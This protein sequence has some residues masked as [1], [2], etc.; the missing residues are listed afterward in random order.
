MDRLFIGKFTIKEQYEGNYYHIKLENEIS[1]FNGLKEGDYVLPSHGGYFGKLLLCNRFEKKDGGIAAIFEVIKSFSPELTLSGNIVCCKYFKP[2]MNLL[3][4]IVKSTKGYG[5]HEISLEENCPN[6][7]IIDFYKSQRRFLVVLKEIL[8]NTNIFKPS[9]ICIVIDNLNNTDIQDIVEFNG[10]KFNK[11]EALWNLYQ[12]KVENGAKKYSLQK[13][14]EFAD[15]RYDAA[16]KKEKYLKSVLSSLADDKYFIADNAVALY[17]NI[18]VGRKQY[19]KSDKNAASQ[20]SDGEEDDNEDEDLTKYEQYAKLME[21]NPNLILYGP[22]G[23]GKTYGAERI[24]EAFEALKGNSTSF[25]ALN[26]E[27]RAKFITFHQ[28]YS[29]EEFVEG[30]RPETDENGNIKY[31]VKPGILKRIAEECRIQETKKN[32]KEK[33]ISNTTGSSKV[34]KV[35]LGRRNL[36]EHIYKSLKKSEEIAIGYG[37][38]ESV[39]DWSDEQIDKADKTGMLKALRSKMQIGDIVFIFDSIRTIRL[40]GVVTSDYYYTDKDSF[41][42]GHRREVKWIKDCEKEPIDIFRLNQEKQLTLSSLYE[43]KISSADALQ[44]IGV[45]DDKSIASRPYY[46]I[47]DEI[48]RGNISKIFGE[49]IT[50]IEKDKRENL[51]CLLPYSGQKFTLPKN[52]YIIGT[53]NTSD[54]SIALLDTALR[55]RFAFIEINPDVSVIESNKTTIG[56]YVSHGKLLSAIN[57]KITEKI[58][59]DHR[60]GHSYFLGDDFNSKMDLFNVWYYKILPLLME[61]FYNDINKVREIV[62]DKFFDQRTKEIVMLSTK[63]NENG[64]SDFESALM[65]IYESRY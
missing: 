17:D 55:R 11:Y 6:F 65:K 19:S 45:K 62:G 31:E 14:L 2:D 27:G 44:Y 23:T 34:W 15:D 41:G 36:E 24:I 52:L 16:P 48:N 46:L 18:L 33:V 56:G 9:D 30:L 53:M 37:P 13:L 22:P 26:D 25:K 59:R 10:Q 3:N 49:L 20:G 4:K 47:I 29:Y 64:I 5:F 63:P 60:I 38:E 54:R 58:D 32:I 61:Y 42:Y 39:L 57:E 1:R 8:S 12:E 21:F 7:E 51:H 28:A 50:L 43:L 35:S 40:I